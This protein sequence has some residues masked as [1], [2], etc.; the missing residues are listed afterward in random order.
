VSL[1]QLGVVAFHELLERIDVAG[2]RF[3]TSS[4]P[5]T[6]LAGEPIMIHSTS[7]LPTLRKQWGTPAGTRMALPARARMS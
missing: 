6:A 2:G 5:V 4:I 3:P 7:S 1:E